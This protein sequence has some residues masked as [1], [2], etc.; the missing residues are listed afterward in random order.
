[1]VATRVK[2]AAESKDDTVSG[3]VMA[4]VFWDGSGVILIDYLQKGAT[5]NSAYYANL[6]KNDL[7]EALRRKRPGKLT[8]VPILL[9]DNASSHTANHTQDVLQRLGWKILMHPP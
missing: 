7:R 8:K 1:M 6:L 2:S 9:H 3:K 5:I 4:T